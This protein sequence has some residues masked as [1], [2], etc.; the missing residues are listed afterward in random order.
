MAEK[1]FTVRVLEVSKLLK[2]KK[3]QEHTKCNHRKSI[4]LRDC[5]ESQGYQVEITQE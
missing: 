2:P 3:V 1:L 5:F 4:Q